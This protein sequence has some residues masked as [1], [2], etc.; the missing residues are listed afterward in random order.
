[1]ATYTR[2]NDVRAAHVERAGGED[3]VAVAREELLAES[4]FGGVGDDE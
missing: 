2:W 3:A 1:M 4:G